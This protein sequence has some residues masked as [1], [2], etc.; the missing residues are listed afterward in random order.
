[1]IGEKGR[2][3]ERVRELDDRAK[4]AMWDKR[5]EQGW[6]KARLIGIVGVGIKLPIC[7]RRMSERK[8]KN[9]QSARQCWN[10]KM[11]RW[12]EKVCSVF[13]KGALVCWFNDKQLTFCS[14]L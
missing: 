4:K 8:E 3:R 1:M 2:Q 11:E 5:G 13:V 6:R 7:I 12:R 9:D 10:E 14:I